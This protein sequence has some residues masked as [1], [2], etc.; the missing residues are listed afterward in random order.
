MQEPVVKILV[1]RE[2]Y[3]AG[4]IRSFSICSFAGAQEDE[5]IRS[6]GRLLILYFSPCFGFVKSVRVPPFT[7]G[8]WSPERT[9]TPFIMDDGNRE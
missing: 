9:S 1:F 6:N 5:S 2:E 3:D 8:R 7:V 4:L